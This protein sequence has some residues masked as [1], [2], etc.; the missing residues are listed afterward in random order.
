ME[1]ITVSKVISGRG[2]VVLTGS[3][4]DG[5]LSDKTAVNFS[6]RQTVFLC[7]FLRLLDKKE[8][9]FFQQFLRNE[10]TI[11]FTVQ[12]LAA[13]SNLARYILNQTGFQ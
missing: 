4:V 6:A 8:C 7:A 9:G 11:D 13:V 10:L 5:I 3:S 1:E 2:R 12:T